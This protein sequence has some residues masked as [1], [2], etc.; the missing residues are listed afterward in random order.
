[1]GLFEKVSDDIK[2]AMLAK[3]KVKLEALRG[4]KKEFLEA[5][6]AKGSDGELTDEQAVK[7]LQKMVKQRKDSASIYTEQGRPELAETELAEATVIEAYLPQQMS[8]EE[9]TAAIQAIVAQVGATGPKEMGKVM[10]VAS[11]QLAGKAEGR[12]I[13][14]KVK[15]ILNSL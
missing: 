2:A 11:K 7:I 15:S 5:K 1:M 14:E 3:E 6:T 12:L 4:I 8:D 10:G 9:L 13:S